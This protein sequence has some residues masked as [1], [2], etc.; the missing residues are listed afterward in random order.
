MPCQG[1][2]GGIETN[3][4]LK[5]LND[6]WAKL[7]TKQ[8]TM[9]IKGRSEKPT[10]GYLVVPLEFMGPPLESHAISRSVSMLMCYSD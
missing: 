8:S 5:C 10:L 1:V 6:T 4:R 2:T 3:I 7:Y 9:H